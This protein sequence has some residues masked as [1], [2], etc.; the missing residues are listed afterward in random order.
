MNLLRMVGATKVLV[1]ACALA[2]PVGLP[3]A[4]ANG[5]SFGD[6]QTRTRHVRL[7]HGFGHHSFRKFHRSHRFFAG[8]RR[9]RSVMSGIDDFPA[10]TSQGLPDVQTRT[11]HVR[12]KHHFRG[13][14]R[15]D[16]RRDHGVVVI[17][18]GSGFGPYDGVG[19]YGGDDF[20]S[21]TPGIGTYAGGI[22]AFRQEG[23]GIYFSQYGGDNYYTEGAIDPA[24][25]LKRAKIIVV[26]P[27]SNDSACS[28]EHGVCVIRP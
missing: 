11:R 25:P 14:A 15:R 9:H 19:S 3:A 12:L 16:W 20:P 23:N 5:A 4:A 18:G 28:W 26:S 27:Q 21:V 1:L 8:H 22:S 7:K 17:G 24:P 13:F 6:V 10:F 2:M